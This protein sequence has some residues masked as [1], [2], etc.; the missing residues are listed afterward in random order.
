M[1]DTFFDLVN[2]IDLAYINKILINENEKDNVFKIFKI[3]KDS[4]YLAQIAEEI[5]N[6]KRRFLINQIGGERSKSSFK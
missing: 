1:M 2:K 6:I 5:K 4:I 3:L